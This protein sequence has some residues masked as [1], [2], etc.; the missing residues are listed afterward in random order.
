VSTSGPS[1]DGSKEELEE[2]DEGAIIA[3]QAAP[4]PPQ[5]RARVA[6]ESR[7]IVIAEEAAQPASRPYRA[8][9]GEATVVIRD[10][11][12][13]DR[14]R[15]KILAELHGKP[16]VPRAV[17]LGLVFAAFA[18]VGSLVIVWVRAPRAELTN[19]VAPS[20]FAAE[21]KPA[22]APA[23]SAP[24]SRA[25]LPTPQIS[26]EQLPLERKRRSR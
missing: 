15:K 21:M 6:D 25:E 18:I 11:R 3:H 14:A 17:W 4:H 7:S 2:L 12:D 24:A 9:R 22:L 1:S 13:L 19:V 26:L 16:A 5:R 10:R 8:D 23:P 20:E